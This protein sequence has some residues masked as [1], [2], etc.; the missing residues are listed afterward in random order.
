MPSP[1]QPRHDPYVRLHVVVTPPPRQVG[2]APIAKLVYLFCVGIP[3]SLM[4]MTAGVFLCLTI[5]GIPAG[6]TCFALG[7]QVLKL[8]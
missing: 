2:L 5:V 6:L 4:L 8:G 7:H 3:L 1:T